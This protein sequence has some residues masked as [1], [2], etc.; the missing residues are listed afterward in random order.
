MAEGCEVLN[1]VVSLLLLVRERVSYELVGAEGGGSEEQVPAA[2]RRHVRPP[3]QLQLCTARP[4]SGAHQIKAD[5]SA[6]PVRG[7]RGRGQLPGQGQQR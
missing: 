6:A 3:S 4:S 2:F 5:E 1:P 7:I